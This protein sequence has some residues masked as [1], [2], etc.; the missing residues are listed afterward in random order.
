[1]RAGLVKAGGNNAELT[2]RLAQVLLDMGRTREAEPLIAQYRRLVGGEEPDVYYRYLTGFS[3]LKDDHP[4]E[5][6]QTLEALRFKVPKGLEPHLYDV[7]GKCYQRVGDT[8]RAL[9]AYRLAT[10]ANSRWVSP[11]VEIANLQGPENLDD[12]VRVL[13]EGIAANPEEAKLLV[14]LA[15]ILWRQQAQLEAGKRSWTKLEDVLAKARKV[16]PN[17]V[18]LALVEADYLAGINKSADSLQVLEKASKINPKSTSLVLA[19]ANLLQRLGR[20]PEATAL[21]DRAIR[22]D[23]QSSLI[24]PRAAGMIAQGHV[25]EAR[26]SL[27]DALAQVPRDQQPLI[28]K[29]LGEFYQGQSNYA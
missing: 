19:R 16:A 8:S 13:E 6:I 5:A 2:W 26:T 15:L 29:A 17:S 24:I 3:A 7:L 9:A 20:T 1:W 28:W 27:L 4:S 10:K 18:E 21:L 12:A 25:K 23:P 11:W 14:N 22:A